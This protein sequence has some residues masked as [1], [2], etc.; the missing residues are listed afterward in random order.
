MATL[1]AA[2]W[3]P[4]KLFTA[5]AR[6]I[7]GAAPPAM[8]ARFVCAPAKRTERHP[9]LGELR[10]VDNANP[11]RKSHKPR[12]PNRRALVPVGLTRNSEISSHGSLR[13][14]EV[15]AVHNG[16]ITFS[17][18]VL[19]AFNAATRLRLEAIPPHHHPV[20][21]VLDF[22]DPLPE[23]GFA[24]STSMTTPVMVLISRVRLASSTA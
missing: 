17:A 22:V 5:R 16:E 6:L 11:D 23:S 1:A 10:R 21:I 24:A 20:A 14:A 19:C 15:F 8:T 2:N 3:I 7:V 18:R 13:T 12:R 4:Q 9:R